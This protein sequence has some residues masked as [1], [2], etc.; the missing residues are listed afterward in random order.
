MASGI[1]DP[2]ARVVSAVF[3]Q[4]IRRSPDGR[5]IVVGPDQALGCAA[6]LGLSLAV[7][8]LVAAMMRGGDRRSS[9][10]DDGSRGSGGRGAGLGGSRG[11]GLA[12]RG[13][14]VGHDLAVGSRNQ[15]FIIGLK[16]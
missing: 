15:P 12:S 4:P 2:I 10:D 16:I 7:Y 6:T 11:G 1:A 5:G 9:I 13:E 8:R 3:L 14:G